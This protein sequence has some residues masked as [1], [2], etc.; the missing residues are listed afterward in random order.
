MIYLNAPNILELHLFADDTNLFPNNT[1][2]LNLE[3]NLNGE[4]Q[5]VSLWF[6]VNNLTLNIE[7]PA[8]WYS[9]LPQRRIVDKFNLNTSDMS[10]KYD[11]KVKCLGLIFEPNLNFKIIL[12]WMEQQGFKRYL[13]TI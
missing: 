8:L 9:I 6:Y 2:I 11:N 5:K 7:K 4:L 3:T 1:N 12:T 13:T 10:V